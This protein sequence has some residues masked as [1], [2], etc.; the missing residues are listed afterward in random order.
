MGRPLSVLSSLLGLVGEAWF[1]NSRR[2]LAAESFLTGGGE[3]RLLVGACSGERR[4]LVGACG[5]DWGEA[6]SGMVDGCVCPSGR[7]AD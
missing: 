3:W 5:E 1:C 2:H 4:L 6:C 7:W